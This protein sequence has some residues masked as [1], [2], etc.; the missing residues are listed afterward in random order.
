MRKLLCAALL[1]LFAITLVPPGI[2]LADTAPDTLKIHSVVVAKNLAED[3]DLLFALHYEIAWDNEA[4][5]PED[6]VSQYFVCQLLNAGGS[7]TYAAAAP[8][9][10]IN[11]GYGEG[12]ASFYF[13][14][15]Q[16]NILG[17]DWNETYLVRV[18]SK[19]GWLSPVE[20]Y[21][22]TISDTDYC[23]S[24]TQSGNRTWLKSW[25]LEVSQSLETDWELSTALTT[26]SIES[27]LS[28][29]GERYFLRVIPGL[30]YL[31]PSLFTLNVVCPADTTDSGT[32][33]HGETLGDRSEYDGTFVEGAL[34][35]LDDLTDGHTTMA[36]NVFAVLIIIAL[37]AVSHL[38]FKTARP[39]MILGLYTL[40]IGAE[41]H[42][43]ELAVVGFIALMYVIFT[44]KILFLD[45]G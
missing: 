28:E 19:V 42:F 33:S 3:G 12:V 37:M 16:V 6:P 13:T 24:D 45:K 27:V 7:V 41:L 26:V 39:G 1:L 23:P 32:P 21:D 31:C 15:D 2:A 36:L 29:Y 40:P 20:K 9:P 5:Y 22:Y 44:A 35:A 25:I 43:T 8:Y 30:R 17:L 4:D 11:N 34:T 14:A 10:F 38:R 18:S